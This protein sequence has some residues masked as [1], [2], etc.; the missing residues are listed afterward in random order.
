MCPASLVYNWES[1]I[2]RFAPDLSV[3]VAVGSS[4]QREEIIK[5]ASGSDILVTSYD[6]LKRD[7]E[8]YKGRTF[9][10]MV[11]DEAQIY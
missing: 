5:S 6:L 11:I 2:G 10:Y 9:P 4:Q 3:A 8:L 1:E 7:A